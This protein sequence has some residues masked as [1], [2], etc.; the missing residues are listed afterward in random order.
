MGISSPVSCEDCSRGGLDHDPSSPVPA[1]I[2]EQ[3][4][5]SSPQHRVTE[6]PATAAAGPRP[7]PHVTRCH[8]TAQGKPD[9]WA[10][11]SRGGMLTPLTQAASPARPVVHMPTC[12][13]CCSPDTWGLP[14]PCSARTWGSGENKD[15]D[16]CAI[17]QT[18]LRPRALVSRRRGAGGGG[19]GGRGPSA[20]H[21]PSWEHG[22]QRT[23]RRG[24]TLPNSDPE[25]G[26]EASEPSD[27]NTGPQATLRPLP[28]PGTGCPGSRPLPA[29][30]LWGS[31]LLPS[32][33]LFNSLRRA[34]AGHQARE[35]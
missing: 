22:G 7:S 31:L 23:G 32:R 17:Q 19:H 27:T 26:S 8:G 10:R 30:V 20:Q 6:N 21:R 5:S 16:S 25:P 18:S 9:L 12:A 33:I 2:T 13:Q 34:V 15:S 11:L 1:S 24:A 28:E 29:A 4:T 14:L 3:P 35:S